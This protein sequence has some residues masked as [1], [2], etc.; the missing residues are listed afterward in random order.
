MA[1]LNAATG[2]ATR[3]P[4]AYASEGEWLKAWR[5]DNPAAPWQAAITPFEMW[6]GKPCPTNASDG[7]PEVVGLPRAQGAYLR[8]KYN[9]YMKKYPS[10]F[11]GGQGSRK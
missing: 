5:T 3:S 8:V 9:Q 6:S 4:A 1:T 10:R 2:N 11:G 7:Q